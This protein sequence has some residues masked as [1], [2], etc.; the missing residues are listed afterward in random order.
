LHQAN[1]RI[2]DAVRGK[3]QQPEEKFPTN[4]DR[5][6]NLSSV[7]IPLLLFEMLESGRIKPGDRLFLSAF[8]AGMTA[9]SCV[10]VWE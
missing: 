7:S 8:G 6:G 1:K 10:I 5:Y 4:I 3:L 2:I 9:G